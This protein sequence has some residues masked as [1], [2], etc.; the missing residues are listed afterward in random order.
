MRGMGGFLVRSDPPQKADIAFVLAG[1]SWGHRVITAAELVRRGYTSQVLVS[2]PSGNYGLHE[3]ELAIPFAVRTG[4]PES[5]F[6]HFENDARSTR[7]ERQAALEEFRRRGVHS[8]LLVTSNFHTRRAGQ[9]FRSA[10]P[11]L[12]ITVVAAPDEFFEP[13]AWWTNREG[14]KIFVIEWLK[15]VAEWIG[16]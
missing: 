7:D 12:K 3:C 16:A 13:G 5:Y 2:G 11:D 10:A 8:L 9:I 1:D 15:T 4:Y 6:L 14:R